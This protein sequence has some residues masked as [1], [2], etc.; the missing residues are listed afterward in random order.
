MDEI[1]RVREFNRAVTRR[2]GV[3]EDRFLGRSRPL[4]AARLLFEIGREGAEVRQLRTR[5]GLD[6]GYVSRMLRDLEREGLVEVGASPGD[7]RVRVVRLTG[8]GRREVDELDR[9]SDAFAAAMLEPLTP[10]LRE[11]LVTAMGDVE[12]LLLASTVTIARADAAGADGRWCLRQYFAELAQ[13]FDTGF[14]PGQSLPFSA[15]DFT[16]PA[17][18]F[19][20][21]TADGG[22]VGCAALKVTAP[23]TGYIKRMWVAPRARGS[24]LGRRIL[25]ALEAQAADMGLTTLQLETNRALTEAIALYR[26]RGFREVAPFNDEPYADHWF[27]KRLSAT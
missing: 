16:P 10:A 3:L 12:R 25:D 26:A 5:L 7:G 2:L 21:A 19:L 15:A 20:T 9:R 4:G 23:G 24:G 6:S 13:R 11:R 8:A 14:D 17:G 18:V 22:P 27:E 1:T